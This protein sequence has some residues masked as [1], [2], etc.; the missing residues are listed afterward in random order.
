MDRSAVTFAKTLRRHGTDA[1]SILWRHLRGRRFAN[2]KFK[3]Q[4]PL[5][6]YVVDFVC[7]A[8]R[9]VVEVDGGQHLLSESDA[10]RDAWL[11]QQGFKVLRFWNNDVLLRTESVLEHLLEHLP[12]SPGPSPTRGEGSK[13]EQRL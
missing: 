4:Q 6:P 10:A 9:V 1:E 8:M 13:S 2:C 7:F 3:R 11:R 5:G 12:L